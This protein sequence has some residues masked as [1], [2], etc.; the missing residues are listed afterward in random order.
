MSR[1]TSNPALYA[2]PRPTG[3]R[4][5]YEEFLDWIEPGVHAEWVD[6]EVVMMAAVGRAH[7]RLHLFLL[8]IIGEFLENHP[9]GELTFDPFN[10]K[11]GEELP[12]RAPDILFVSKKNLKRLK[13][14]HLEGPADMVIEVVSPGSRGVDRGQKFYEYEEGGVPEYWLLDP[15]RK[16]AEFHRRTARGELALVAPDDKGVY[17]CKAIKGLWVDV[18]WFWKYPFPPLRTIRRLWGID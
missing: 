8:R 6:G 14:N 12:G 18:N 2:R 5:S 11:T 4:M 1:A 17:A 16:R 15:Y 7:N 13:D 9:I 3:L 10:M